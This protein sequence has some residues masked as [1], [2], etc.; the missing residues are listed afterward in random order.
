MKRKVLYNK[1]YF[2]TELNGM[3]A[4][5]DI[6]NGQLRSNPHLVRVL[7]KGIYKAV[8]PLALCRETDINP[9]P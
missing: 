4:Q 6:K 7:G 2:E 1:T 3:L 8:L 5:R 9:G